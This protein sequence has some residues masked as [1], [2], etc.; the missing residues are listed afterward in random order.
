MCGAREVGAWSKEL[1]QAMLNYRSCQ[2]ARYKR[3]LGVAT[4]WRWRAIGP[5]ARHNLPAKSWL[6][7]SF[8]A[9]VTPGNFG[10][11]YRVS[12]F[13]FWLAKRVIPATRTEWF[14][15][16]H[17][18]LSEIGVNVCTRKPYLHTHYPSYYQLPSRVNINWHK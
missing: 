1:S 17:T 15:L 4:R 5:A 7:I 9:R 2:S 16:P 3:W 13:A 18:F 11:P 8:Y 12:P 14:I 6:L 10:Q